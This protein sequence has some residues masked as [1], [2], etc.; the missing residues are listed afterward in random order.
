MNNQGL[1]LKVTRSDDVPIVVNFD[2]VIAILPHEGGVFTLLL[3]G[4]GG[5]VIKENIDYIQS[6]IPI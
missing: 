3:T 6:N 2:Q 5:I 4:G 1:W